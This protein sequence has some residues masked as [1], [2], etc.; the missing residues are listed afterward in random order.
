MYRSNLIIVKNEE[1][2]SYLRGMG[3]DVSAM[4]LLGGWKAYYSYERCYL[5]QVI[6]S[7]ALTLSEYGKYPYEL[8]ADDYLRAIQKENDFFDLVLSRQKED[9]FAEKVKQIRDVSVRSA[10]L[11]MEIRLLDPQKKSVEEE[12]KFR[13]KK[14]EMLMLDA[15]L[16]E[17]YKDKVLMYAF[18]YDEEK[19]SKEKYQHI[20]RWNFWL[21]NYLY[22]H[23][24]FSRLLRYQPYI[25]LTYDDA[26]L[27]K[28]ERKKEFKLVKTIRFDHLRIGDLALLCNKDVLKIYRGKQ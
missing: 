26:E 17:F 12:K 8:S 16:E 15:L 14:K 13:E 24:L 3:Y 7:K 23:R 9:D 2:V 11:S 18:C 21:Q 27:S 28:E 6:G 5:T 19:I 22:Y 10:Q 4:D 20:G 25:F 1:A